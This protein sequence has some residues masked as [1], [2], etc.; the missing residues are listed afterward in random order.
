MSLSRSKIPF[1]IADH[2]LFWIIQS[3]LHF[4]INFLHPKI[5]IEQLLLDFIFEK[6]ELVFE[7]LLYF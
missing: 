6:Q 5:D 7:R 3:L 2:F 4:F 1:P